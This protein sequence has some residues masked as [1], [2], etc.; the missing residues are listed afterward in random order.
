MKFERGNIPWSKGKIGIYSEET[1]EK[2]R[3][4]KLGTHPKTEFEKGHIPWNKDKTNIY[5]EEFLKGMS[6]T[7]IENAKTNPNYGMKNKHHSSIAKQKMRLAH[8]GKK[9]S[10]EH[11]AKIGL[12]NLNKKIPE[13]VRIKISESQKGR[14]VP[15]ERC[16]KLKVTMKN[17]WQNP[18][19]RENQIKQILKGYLKRP[20]SLEQQFIDLF[21]QNSLPYKYVGNGSFLIGYKNPDFVNINGEKICIEVRSRRIC[22]IFSKCSPEEYEKRQKEHYSKYGWKCLV[23]WDDS[24]KN[25]DLIEKIKKGSG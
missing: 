9:L 20:T 6:K 19:Y 24:I 16:D 14:K 15:K 12:S 3:V 5:S 17:L 10:E 8:L 13:E 25:P 11:K 7:R 4:A 23:F 18:E 21:Q 2:M 1:I 22:L